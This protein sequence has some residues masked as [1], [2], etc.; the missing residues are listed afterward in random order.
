M[1]LYVVSLKAERGDENVGSNSWGTF[2]AIASASTHP[3]GSH[4]SSHVEAGHYS[5]NFQRRDE[6]EEN[7]RRKGSSDVIFTGEVLAES[8][9][10]MRPDT[11]PRYPHHVF[12][13][14]LGHFEE[15][16]DTLRVQP[17]TKVIKVVGK[18]F[19]YTDVNIRVNIWEPISNMNSGSTYPA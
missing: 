7:G 9:S 3:Q 15:L 8:I 18:S 16:K 19:N 6:V 10:P 4:I 5:P 14:T 12:Q 2:A 17:L 13:R 11:T 1:S